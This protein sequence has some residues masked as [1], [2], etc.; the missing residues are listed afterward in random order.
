MT[1]RLLT[2]RILCAVVA[3]ALLPSL[4]RAQA[5][6]P[7][8]PTRNLVIPPEST[9]QPLPEQYIWTRG[10]PPLGS[11]E[12][13]PRFFRAAF[14]LT[15]VPKDATL[16]LAGPRLA[17]IYLNG[18][19]VDQFDSD[20]TAP[21]LDFRVFATPLT[22]LH[23]GRNVLAMEVVR[24]KGGPKS[25]TVASTIQIAN[26][27]V[28]VAKILPAA[29]WVPT[30]APALLLSDTAWKATL[31]ASGDWQSPAFDDSAWP[32]VASLGPIETD[33]N[34]RQWNTDAGMY[35]WPGYQGVSTF[36]RQTPL[37][38]VAVT[39]V[40][41]G[42]ST[43]A[44][45]DALTKP[46]SA[47]LTVRL[48]SPMLAQQEAPSLVLDFGRETVGR[49][50]IVSTST[51]LAMVA[52]EYGESENELL[53]HPYLGTNLLTLP[54]HA[55]AYGPKSA[56]R[57]ARVRFLSAQA[58]IQIGSIQL[59]AIF[60]PVNYSGSFESSDPLL[61]K[62]WE[63]G[64]YT[65][66]LCMQDGIWDAPKRDRGRWAGDLD[67]SG[68]VID[69]VFA[70]RFL[71]EDTLTRLL[72]DRAAGHHVNSIPGY[73]ALWISAL[74]QY[75]LHTGSLDYL[76]SVHQRLVDLLS[77]MDAEMDVD[78]LFADKSKDWPFVDWTA[79]L[80]ADTPEARRGTQF[81]YILAFRD[82]AFLLRE[83]GDNAAATKRDQAV[84][85]LTAAAQAHLLD[86]ATGTFGSRWQVNSMAILSGA[87]T[88][89][90]VP[91]IWSGVLT[92]TADA[93]FREPPITPFYNY[94]V[95][96]A[97]AASGH[98]TEALDWIRKYWGGMVR[99]GATS[100]WEA[101]DTHWPTN[102]PHVSL[103]A[104]GTSGY[105]VSLA[106]GWSSGPTSWLM[107]EI[108]GIRPTAAGF[109][110]ATLRPDLA[111]LA[112]ARG[113]EPSPQGPI[114]IDLK[115][116]HTTVTL[117]A[118]IELSVLVSVSP[119]H[120]SILLNGKPVTPGPLTEEG[121]RAT[122]LLSQPGTYTLEAP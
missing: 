21:G 44:N 52:I 29:P 37:P 55:T 53:D 105:Y 88:L 45:A 9:R 56:F 102:N 91:A 42:R 96:S 71:M 31:T 46:G 85:Q 87:A 2:A 27:K 39:H 62:I 98:R 115:P 20:L 100:F 117:P 63:T 14:N 32:A 103:Q 114:A 5:A 116:N 77:T 11:G 47:P 67:V 34:L 8:D 28:V 33:I 6:P 64:A 26:G 86:A 61:N 57:Y 48:A 40:F 16:Y 17:K 112:W 15:T 60:Y 79:D 18:K 70:D 49:L 3:L 90:Q 30:E 94:Y 41:S 13:Q 54:A 22:G 51:T 106:H 97:M 36:L 83:L 99:E 73:S 119:G 93:S 113:T 1:T 108:L 69:N 89:A 10:G 50:Q 111:G 118:G 43:I 72:D 104:D 76:K 107:E 59:D 23:T 121:T 74:D 4:A 12:V 110:T 122:V 38:A 19:L 75:Y 81:E 68:R 80:S 101:Y 25:T 35:N 92:H 84:A 66:H 95:L 24:G 82:A 58:P 65:A 120:S 109:R 7:L 78:H